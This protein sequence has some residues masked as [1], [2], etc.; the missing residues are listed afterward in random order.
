MSANSNRF[1]PCTLRFHLVVVIDESELVL[2]DIVRLIMRIVPVVIAAIKKDNRFLLTKR[3]TFDNEDKEY[4]PFAWNLPGGGIEFGETPE[5]ALT[6]EI[7]EELNIDVVIEAHVPKMFTQ[8]RKR[9]QGIFILYLC[10]FDPKQTITL[11]DEAEE[12]GWFTIDE[13]K[14]IKSFPKTIAMM[15][16]ASKIKT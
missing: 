10:R 15:T 4:A 13:A 11:N 7:K 16:E 1:D 14:T 6:R 2:I 9:W 5:E 12:Y 8:V 3:V